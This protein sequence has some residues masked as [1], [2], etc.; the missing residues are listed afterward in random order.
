MPAGHPHGKRAF[1]KMEG[2]GNHFVVCSP[3]S[4]IEITEALTRKICAPHFG[5]GADGV[6]A[7]T[8][9]K[10]PK[11]DFDVLMRNPDGSLM[12]MCGNGIRCVAKYVVDTGLTTKEKLSFVVEGR[13]IECA[14]HDDIVDVSMGRAGLN[15]EE[16]PL[17][18]PIDTLS[19]KVEAEGVTWDVTAV[20]MG[21]PHAVIFVDSL[22]SPADLRRIGAAIEH[23]PLFP[24]RTNVEFVTITDP[25]HVDVLVWERA[26]G[27]TLACGTGAC[28]AVVAGGRRGLLSPEVRVT[29]PGGEVQVFWDKITQNV[30]LSGYA[31]K[32]FEGV[33]ENI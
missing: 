31:R 26:A 21:N 28:A 8:P 15:A 24:Q 6:M 14:V 7:I 17:R 20:S 12:G 33:M 11:I 10:D 25:T 27:A 19:V 13:I 23:H 9:S 4:A 3:E 16:I 22:P 5:V 18:D 29:L 32:V 30:I 2:C 1:W